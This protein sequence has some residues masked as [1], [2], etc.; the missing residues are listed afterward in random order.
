[1]TR[2]RLHSLSLKAALILALVA[3]SLVFAVAQNYGNEP[4]PAGTEAAQ[5]AQAPSASVGIFTVEQADRGATVF[6]SNCA[7][8]HGADL[9]GGFGPS[10]APLGEHWQG[11][12]LGALFRFVSSNM[13][14]S[15]PGSLAA[16]EYL[17][18]VAF[19]LR[20]NGYPAGDTAL[21]A[22]AAIIDPV[23]L[24]AQPPAP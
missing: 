10:L 9:S 18:V 14:F 5:A 6:S 8:C 24:D 7:G 17:D 4:P 21:V 22:D 20:S 23:L 12:S 19:V 2:A 16:E 1:M 3:S 15:A 13:P 11:Q